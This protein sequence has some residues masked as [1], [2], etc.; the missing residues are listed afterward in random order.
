MDFENNTSF[1]AKLLTSVLDEN[2]MAGAVIVRATFDLRNGQLLPS[3]QQPWIVSLEPWESPLGP[4]EADQPYRKG[5]VDLFV[6]GAAHTPGGTPQK[7]VAVSVEAGKFFFSAMVF[8]ARTWQKPRPK[9]AL[10]PS[11]PIPFITLPLTP[12][13]AFGG[14]MVIDGLPSP[15]MDN[16]KGLG[17]YADEEAA[18][19][20]PLPH[21][22]NAQALIRTWSDRP[23]PV[24]FGVCPLQNG[25][26][27]RSAVEFVDG[28]FERITSRLF[29]AASPHLVAPQ[30]D[31][32]DRVV[33]TGFSP[34]GPLEFRIPPSSLLVRL[35]VGPTE[36][37]RTPTIEE[38]GIDVPSSQVFLGYR[39]PFRYRFVAHQQRRCTLVS[40][41]A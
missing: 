2:R 4:F 7:Q 19:N 37:E 30:I 26:R 17:L 27:L 14:R 6:H 32:G 12:E 36:V 9:S 29:N 13:Y 24:S 39:Y 5:G 15:H 10:V 38:V 18:L 21:I 16:P 41:E 35:Q 8:G 25:H 20:Q 33:L 31:P 22:E 11:D 1:P 23:D 3:A 28:R 34:E 40:R